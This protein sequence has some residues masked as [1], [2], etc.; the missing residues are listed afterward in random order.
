VFWGMG[1][2][3]L[4][5]SFPSGSEAVSSSLLC[6]GVGHELGGQSRGKAMPNNEASIE[7][8]LKI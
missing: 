4:M 5:L 6:Q 7:K 8:L 2:F 1:L 3:V